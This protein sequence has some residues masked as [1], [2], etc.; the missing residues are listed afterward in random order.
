MPGLYHDSVDCVKKQF[1]QSIFLQKMPE[2]AQRCFI[3]Y[4][5]G[6]E[7]NACE[8]PHGIAVIDGILCCRVRE[9]G[10]ALE[11]ELRDQEFIR[12]GYAWNGIN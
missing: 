10:D 3:W 9:V 11:N 1:A 8:F 4:C 6:H 7:V 5:F 12:M 2:F